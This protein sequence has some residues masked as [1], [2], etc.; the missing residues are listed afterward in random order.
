M[1][2]S[3]SPLLPLGSGPGDTHRPIPREPRQPPP[4]QGKETDPGEPG[5]GRHVLGWG[6][7]KARYGWRRGQGEGLYVSA[8]MFSL[9]GFH[10]A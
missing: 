8:R 10:A 6:W 2:F 3:A 1:L 5:V 9:Y 4:H 7:R